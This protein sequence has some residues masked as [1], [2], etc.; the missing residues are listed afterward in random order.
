MKQHLYKL[1][2]LAFFA[3]TLTGAAL[4]QDEATLFRA[5]IPVDFYVGDKLMPAGEY[6]I[7]V[8][9][10]EH[11]LAIEEK[12]TGH[13]CFLLGSPDDGSRDDRTVLTFKLVAGDV[14]ALRE[15]QAPDL[16]L[17]FR[18]KA[19]QTTAR[20]QKQSKE[21]ITVIAEAK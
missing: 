6:K 19:P 16:G 18:A 12:A 4:A 13:T 11:D 17:S 21:T 14:Y 10:R 9:I 3:A 2:A 1:A 7:L 8:D 5:N 15:F 20:A